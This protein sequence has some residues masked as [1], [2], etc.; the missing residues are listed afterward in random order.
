[1]QVSD[2]MKEKTSQ[3][4]F[5]ITRISGDRNGS[6]VSLVEVNPDN[7]SEYLYPEELPI[8]VNIL[9]LKLFYE[10]FE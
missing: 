3:K 7:T 9:E 6:R 2:L 10:P 4:I 5:I 1:M 8:I